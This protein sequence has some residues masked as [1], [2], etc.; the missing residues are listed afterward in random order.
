MA[1]REANNPDSPLEPRPLDEV[2]KFIPGFSHNANAHYRTEDAR[3]LARNR[4]PF[5]ELGNGNIIEFGY[6]SLKPVDSSDIRP[7]NW[8]KMAKTIARV[9]DDY[10]GFVILH[11]TD[12]MAFTSSALSFMFENLAKPVVI[13]GSQLPLSNIHTDAIKNLL[14]A[15]YIAGYKATNLPLIPEVVIVFADRIIRG[16]RAKKVSTSAPAGFDSPNYPLLGIIGEQIEINTSHLLAAPAT[17]KKFSIKAVLETNIFYINIFPGFRNKQ[18]QKLFLD[19]NIKGIVMRTY[20]AGNIPNKKKFL[21][22]VRQAVDSGKLVVNISQ[23]I[24]GSVEMGLYAPSSG[25]LKCGV[26]SGLDMT[27]EAA[28]TKLMWILGNQSGKHRNKQMQKSLR[29]ELSQPASR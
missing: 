27:P 19:E 25:L 5:L 2:L 3:Q 9:Y 12:T 26:I 10:D 23:C 22:T 24:N 20:G 4:T 18:M 7:K 11:G 21:D 16:C 17:N 28:L 14:N 29:G 13:T 6:A 8:R 15:F 1:T